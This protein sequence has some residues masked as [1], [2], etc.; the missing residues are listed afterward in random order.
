LDVAT[1][2]SARTAPGSPK[3]DE[4]DLACERF[5]GNGSTVVAADGKV[6]SFIVCGK[7][8]VLSIGVG[9]PALDRRGARCGGTGDKLCLRVG[10]L[11]QSCENTAFEQ[12]DGWI[13]WRIFRSLL[14]DLVGTMKE[15]IAVL[16]LVFEDEG[17]GLKVFGCGF[18]CGR[19]SVG[20]PGG[21][22]RGCIVWTIH[23]ELEV[24]YQPLAFIAIPFGKL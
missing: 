4:Y 9:T 13:G 20:G 23:L 12:V 10:F 7:A 24:Y 8:D 19:S 17:A 18:L 2:T 22:G 21:S 14:E 5:Q 16:I 11:L 1:V 15:R 6:R 3:I